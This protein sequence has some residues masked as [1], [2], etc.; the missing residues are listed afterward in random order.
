MHRGRDPSHSEGSA[1]HLGMA[2]QDSGLGACSARS[3]NT[4][5]TAGSMGQVYAD[6]QG[7]MEGREPA[8]SKFCLF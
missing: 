6:R 8:A 7:R 3:P 4:G 2:W 1:Q 5:L